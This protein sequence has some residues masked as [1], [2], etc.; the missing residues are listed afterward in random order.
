[1]TT[2]NGTGDPE[3]LREAIRET[4]AQLGETVQALAARADVRTR[5][6]ESAVRKKDQLVR[7]AAEKTGVVRGQAGQG[8]AAVRRKPLPLV[9][10]AAGAAAVAIVV[11][12]VRGRRR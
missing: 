6:K 9:V 10:L 11:L 2:G 3:A 5:L 12:V 7:Q 4:R 1:M 8:A